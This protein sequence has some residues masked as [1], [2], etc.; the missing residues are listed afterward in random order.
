LSA[1]RH[2]RAREE[3]DPR[4]GF[5][6]VEAL[7][8]LAVLA[9]VLLL[10]L[11]LVWQQRRVLLRLEAREAAD[12]A[13]AE[14]L[15]LLRSGGMP[16]VSAVVPVTVPVGP[17]EGL[18]VVA[19]VTRAEPPPDLFHALLVARYRVAGATELRT[20]ETQL[21]RPDLPRME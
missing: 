4:A 14:A 21:W 18:E 3:R 11:G 19:R 9:L 10:G 12:A 17:A 1:E 16:P 20:V 2:A 5:A 13:L 15:E 7:V 8:A 6:L